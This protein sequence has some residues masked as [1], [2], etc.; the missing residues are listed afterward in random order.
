MS[1]PT[2]GSLRAKEK[3]NRYLISKGLQKLIP[4]KFRDKYPECADGRRVRRRVEQ[5]VEALE[6]VNAIVPVRTLVLQDLRGRESIVPLGTR[7]S[8]DPRQ[9]LNTMVSSRTTITPVQDRT[10]GDKTPKTLQFASVIATY[11][12]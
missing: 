9:V 12:R 6:A 11:W 5:E 4:A 2:H 7:L 8:H 1:L 10:A 3:L